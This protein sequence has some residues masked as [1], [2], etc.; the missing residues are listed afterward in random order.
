MNVSQGGS[1][2]VNQ[3]A[4]S[5]YPASYTFEDGSEVRL[6]AVP[7][8]G[9]QFESWSGDLAGTAN[10]GTVVIDCN[11]SVTANFSPAGRPLITWPQVNW[12]VVGWIASCLVLAGL[13]VTVL[14]VRR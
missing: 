5:S 1:V 8:A 7:A 6:E 4:P 11:K 10:P 14:I 9:Y 12:P 3:A 13:L 2:I